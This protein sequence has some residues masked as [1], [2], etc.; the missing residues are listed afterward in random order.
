LW[1]LWG[2]D[3]G[4]SGSLS[5]VSLLE[6]L[7]LMSWGTKTGMATVFWRGTTGRIYVQGGQVVHAVFAGESGEAAAHRLLAREGGSFTWEPG[8]AA[9]P[10]TITTSTQNLIIEA[11]RLMDEGD[12]ASRAPDRSPVGKRQLSIAGF[13]YMPK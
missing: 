13:F 8:P 11:A 3:V 9:C 5:D 7:Q 4:I 12:D 10:T 1:I 6:L 2:W